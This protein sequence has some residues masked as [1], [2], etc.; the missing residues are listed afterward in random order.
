M[1][2]PDEDSAPPSD[3]DDSIL[4]SDRAI[5]V[6]VIQ[7]IIKKFNL[8]GIPSIEQIY[9]AIEEIIH[10][11]PYLPPDLQEKSSLIFGELFRKGGSNL[12]TNKYLASKLT[13]ID[14][15]E[16]F[17][18]LLSILDIKEKSIL[19][20][21]IKT[22]RLINQGAHTYS[23]YVKYNLLDRYG[24]RE[25]VIFYIFTTGDIYSLIRE[26][27]EEWSKNLYSRDWEP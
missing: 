13:E 23:D 4:T 6:H 27:K 7:N 12:S 2:S 22:R 11:F 5:G 8:D 25:R 3:E 26:Q 16:Q 17:R 9:S 10:Y 19:L 21:A 14:V 24:T 20:G 1:N 15:P 18:P